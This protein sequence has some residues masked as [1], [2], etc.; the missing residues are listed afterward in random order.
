MSRD[1]RVDAYVAKSAEFARPILTFLRET[2]HQACP[3]VEETIKWGFPHFTYHGILCSMAAFKGHCAFG[4]WKGELVL[5]AAGKPREAM[6]QFG[7]IT[8]CRDLP[9]KAVI[10]KYIR[11]AMRLNED[12]EA[13]PRAAPV[14][15]AV[16]VPRDLTAALGRSPR[17]RAVF[18]RLPPSHRREYLEW[19]TE[20]KRPETRAR[21]I[22]TTV[23]WLSEGKSRNWKYARP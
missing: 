6:G 19:I 20:A 10:R 21:R 5:G 7:R 11:A 8:D 2:V 12:G 15:R 9:A 14:R 18:A 4:F 13:V 1:P 17:A 23:T 3:E 16:A 22:A